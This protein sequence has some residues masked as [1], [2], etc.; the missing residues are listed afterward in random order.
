[1]A[2]V[3]VELW[4]IVFVQHRFMRT[5]IPKAVLQVVVGGSLVLA[6]GV[7]LGGA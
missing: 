7:L 4:V 5:P 2:I 3:F 6:V 1:M